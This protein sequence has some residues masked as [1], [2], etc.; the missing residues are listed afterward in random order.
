MVKSRKRKSRCKSKA[1]RKC[2]YGQLKRPVRNKEWVECDT[3][4]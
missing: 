1:R 3:V 2:K 4:S